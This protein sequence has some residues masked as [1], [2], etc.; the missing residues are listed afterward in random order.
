[1]DKDRKRK[2]SFSLGFYPGLL[3]GMRT[4]EEETQNAYV[5]Y[6]PFVDIALEIYK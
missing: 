4:Y 6:L 5:I 3:L 2:W 1:M